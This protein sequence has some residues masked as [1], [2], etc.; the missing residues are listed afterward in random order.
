MSDKIFYNKYLKYKNKYIEFKKLDGGVNPKGKH[1]DLGNNN[2]YNKVTDIQ[3]KGLSCFRYDDDKD[4][5]KKD[6]TVCRSSKYHDEVT[7][8]NTIK[9]I[10]NIWYELDKTWKEILNMWKIGRCPNIFP[11]NGD[12]KD[13]YMW[14][15]D[16][17]DFSKGDELNKKFTFKLVRNNF[18]N[19]CS[20]NFSNTQDCFGNKILEKCIGD[21]KFIEFKS[22]D[23]NNLLI[24][25]C[26]SNKND[27]KNDYIH[28]KLFIKN[29]DNIIKE[30]LWK[31][32]YTIIKKE[33]IDNKKHLYLHTDGRSVPY[34]HLRLI[35]HTNLNKERKNTRQL[36]FEKLK[37]VDVTLT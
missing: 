30:K 5:K 28:L 14:E 11:T 27:Y 17:I 10:S 8:S 7:Q 2:K 13:G 31:H 16:S 18:T 3:F 29:S 21:I 32:L 33:F 4:E 23:N 34:L 26:P 36:E 1:I 12:E 6:I 19:T 22:I 9:L 15:C 24:I 20:K 35:E 37:N 25:P